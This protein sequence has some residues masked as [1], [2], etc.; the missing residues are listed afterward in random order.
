[1][2][3]KADR[4]EFETDITKTCESVAERGVVLVNLTAGSGVAIGESAGKADLVANPS[5]YTVAGVLLNDVVSTDQTKFH[6]NYHK[7]ET[8]A[9]ARCRLLKKGW[10]ITNK[11]TGTPTNGATAY[12][13]TSGV[14]TPTVSSTGGLAATPKVGQFDSIKDENSY[15]KLTVNLPIN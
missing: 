3:L 2:A 4:Y 10:V 14:V 15:V 13:T 7:D 11:V 5:G 8:K 9:G 12:L 1:M 6:I